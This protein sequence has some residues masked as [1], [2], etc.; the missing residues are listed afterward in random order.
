MTTKL[1]HSEVK[2]HIEVS[3]VV[4]SNKAIECLK[5][6]QQFDNRELRS[7]I[8]TLSEAIITFVQ[9]EISVGA[10]FDEQFPTAKETM[11]KLTMLRSD[12]QNLV[13]P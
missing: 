5:G 9:L 6:K 4:L 12:L 1:Q 8:E 13:K 7:D 2:S 11:Q 3:G 10:D